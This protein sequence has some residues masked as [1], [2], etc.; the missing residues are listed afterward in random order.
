M[1]PKVS[2]QKQKPNHT[3]NLD[4]SV[5]KQHL[6]GDFNQL[7][8]FGISGILCL[9]LEQELMC[10]NNGVKLDKTKLDTIKK[11]FSISSTA[12]ILETF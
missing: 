10:D 3:S 2:Q 7:V 12:H 6:F 9:A 11:V 8:S 4:L 5:K 1:N